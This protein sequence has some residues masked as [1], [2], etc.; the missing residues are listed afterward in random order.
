MRAHNLI[1]FGS[2]EKEEDEAE[3][4]KQDLMMVYKLLAIIGAFTKINDTDRIGARKDDRIRPI[5]VV[6]N[7]EKERDAVLKNMYK[8]KNANKV[9]GKLSVRED[10]TLEQRNKRRLLLDEAIR[11]NNE[12]D[13]TIGYW[14]VGTLKTGWRLRQYRAKAG[15]REEGIDSI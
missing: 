10:C 3:Q 6:L 14:K 13:S 1:I 12:D 4:A 15:P 9:Y 2:V 11:R 8:Y 7:A 5:K